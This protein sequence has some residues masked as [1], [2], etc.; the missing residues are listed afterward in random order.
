MPFAN[1]TL[2]VIIPL[3]YLTHFVLIKSYIRVL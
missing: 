1:I 2:T 3:L